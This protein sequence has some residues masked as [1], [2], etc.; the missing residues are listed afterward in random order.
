MAPLLS[1]PPVPL[2]RLGLHELG[3][4]PFGPPYYQLYWQ[5][6]PVLTGRYFGAEGLWALAERYF[7]CE[8]WHTLDRGKG[9]ITSLLAFDLVEQ[10]QCV[11]SHATRGFIR[12]VRVEGTTLIYEKTFLDRGTTTEYERDIQTLSAW[13][14]LY[15]S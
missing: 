6:R 11:V 4:I 8:E 5:Q 1:F 7:F 3:E 10:R 13:Q 9:P 12:P 15:L 2:E 14:P